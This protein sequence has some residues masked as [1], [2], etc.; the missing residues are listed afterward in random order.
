MPTA[1]GKGTSWGYSPRENVSASQHSANHMPE[2]WLVTLPSPAMRTR[3]P[4]P[5]WQCLL[6]WWLGIPILSGTQ[7]GV[8]CLKCQTAL[9]CFGDHMVCCIKNDIQRRHL[10]LQ[11]SLADF[12]RT[13]GY[14]CDLEKGYGDGTRAADILIPRWDSNGPAAVDVTIRCPLALHNPLRDHTQ[15]PQWQRQQEE[16][17]QRKYGDGCNR[18]GWDFHPFVVDTW[19]GLGPSARAFITTL[20]RRATGSQSPWA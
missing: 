14:P 15:L 17:K 10:A 19:G 18:M 16:D 7:Q 13:V 3:V 11:T 6:K 20:V 9:D 2:F 4:S 12:V 8:P 1:V 5:S